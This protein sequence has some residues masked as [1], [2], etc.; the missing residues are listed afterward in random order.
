MLYK[1]FT[2]LENLEYFSLLAKRNYSR[3]ELLTFLEEAGLTRE[4][5]LNR[6]GTYSKGMRQKTGIAIAMAKQ[7]Q[8]LLLDEP[9]SGLDRETEEAFLND[10]PRA[11]MGR[12]LLLVTHAQLPPEAKLRAL[13]MSRGQLTGPQPQ[14]P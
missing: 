10:I 4:Q 9:T 14:R 6:V 8:A 7:A 11:F 2:G 12:T 13:T 5:A 1:N 3:E